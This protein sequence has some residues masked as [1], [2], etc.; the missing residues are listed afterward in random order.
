MAEDRINE[1]RDSGP[2]K[3]EEET[4]RNFLNEIQA[5][6]ASS[7]ED[8]FSKQIIGA[9]NAQPDEAGRIKESQEIFNSWSK[10][11]APLET[12]AKELD[13]LKK[14][15]AETLTKML[16]TNEQEIA[17]AKA[18]VEMLNMV[19]PLAQRRLATSDAEPRLL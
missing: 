13:E 15:D 2:K 18:I 14:L 8:N 5:T 17:H 12:S 11:A 19:S 9:I 3:P 10:Q 4:S 7:G 6:G 16:K 1:I